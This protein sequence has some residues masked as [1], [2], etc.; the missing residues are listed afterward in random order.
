VQLLPLTSETMVVVSP[1]QSSARKYYTVNEVTR[2]PV[3]ATRGIRA[4]VDEQFR[5]HGKQLTVEYEISSPEAIRRLLFRGIGMTILPVSTFRDDIAS[6]QLAAYPIEDVNLHRML[7]VGH[8]PEP[9]L[10]AVRALAE[11]IRAEVIGLATQGY[12]STIPENGKRITKR[13]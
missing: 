10:P 11:T 2:S 3:I 8:L 1:P 12:F 7:A 9:A 13:R 6:G 5:A 4:M